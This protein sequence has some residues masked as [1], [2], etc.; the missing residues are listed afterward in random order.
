MSKRVFFEKK[1]LSLFENPQFQRKV[2]VFC[3]SSKNVSTTNSRHEKFFPL[4]PF[5]FLI[6]DFDH[7]SNENECHT[8]HQ[9]V[10]PLAPWY[11][12]VTSNWSF[13]LQSSRQIRRQ[14]LSV[15]AILSIVL[16]CC[17]CW[18]S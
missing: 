17:I 6:V 8:G 2:P 5:N 15:R 12:Q 13:G 3:E 7:G 11:R 10:V 9:N 1:R 14:P 18:L 4:Q 16:H